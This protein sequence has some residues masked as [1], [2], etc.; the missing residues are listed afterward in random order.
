MLD[1]SPVAF[2]TNPSAFPPK[3][4]LKRSASTA[5][6]LTPPRTHRKHARGRSRGSCDSESEIDSGADVD[7]DVVL[8]S[9]DDM[10][11]SHKKRRRVGETAEKADEDAFWLS[12]APGTGSA[13]LNPEPSAVQSSSKTSSTSTSSNSSAKLQA[14]AP[15]L[16]RRLLAQQTQAEIEVDVAPV[17]PPPSHRKT[18]TAVNTDSPA[19]VSS[20]SPPVTPRAGRTTR[21][22]TKLAFRDSPD[23]PFLATPQHQLGDDSDALSPT[24][25]PTASASSA[26]PSP[27][28]PTHQEKPTLTYVFRGV[29]RVYQ[30]PLYNH[31]EDRPY[32]PPPASKLPLDHP[33]YS[34]AIHCTP[35]LLFADARR[36]ARKGPSKLAKGKA[37]RPRATKAGSK[38]RRSPS[39]GLSDD[40][41]DGAKDIRPMKL[42]FGA[43]ATTLAQELKDVGEVL[44]S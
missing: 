5:S 10:G 6:L 23:N 42:A 33:D 32:S 40:E 26:N 28:T 16:Y 1:S 22:A 21:S 8:T 14:A 3:R 11:P 38:R 43:S 24:R 30:N 18:T 27:H 44:S 12:G 39:P 36:G 25:S 19:T 41:D 9:D 20:V 35:K 31:A 7:G 34:P 29:R 37:T 17:S 2:P 4:P 15:L 13:G